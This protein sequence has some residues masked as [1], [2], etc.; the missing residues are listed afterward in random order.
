MIENQMFEESQNQPQ[1]HMQVQA[2]TEQP[3]RRKGFKKP[4][5]LILVLALIITGLVCVYKY[6]FG[7]TWGS[8]Y[9]AIFLD[10]SQVYF[11][12]LSQKDS[13]YV[14][15]EDVY[16]LRVTT[17]LQTNEQGEQV[18]V[19]DIN[20]V[21]LGTELHKPLDRMEIQKAHILFIEKLADDSSVIDAINTYKQKQKEDASVVPGNG[22]APAKQ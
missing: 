20:L 5:I 9:Y 21:K 7:N 17:A 22:A 6:K 8:G 13:P 15:L 19:P 14:V 16:Y 18:Q 2:Q 10:N 3:K 1:E 4:L 11:G 12:N